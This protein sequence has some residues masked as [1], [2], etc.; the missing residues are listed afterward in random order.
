[1]CHAEG[2]MDYDVASTRAGELSCGNRRCVSAILRHRCQHTDSMSMGC[3]CRAT[4][5]RAGR[6]L[7][8]IGSGSPPAR[9]VH[10]QSEI[11]ERSC[12]D[13]HDAIRPGSPG[14][15]CLFEVVWISSHSR[16]MVERAIDCMPLVLGFETSECRIKAPSLTI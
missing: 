6:S 4:V 14:C 8:Y 1:M 9:A 5:S 2:A 3:A 15:V 7:A 16:L 10:P 11:H 12:D 13:A